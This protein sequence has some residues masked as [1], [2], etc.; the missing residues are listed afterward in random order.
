[1]RRGTTPTNTFKTKTDVTGMA[2]L[3]ITY[4]QGGET[5]IEKSLPDIDIYE[6]QKTEGEETITI[7]VMETKLTQEETL[8]LN[9]HGEVE[10]QVRGKYTDGSVIACPVIKAPVCRIL[11]EGVI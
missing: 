9:S 10:I 11:K 6:E 5:I 4:M 7:Y 8:A 1:M 3:F 2:A